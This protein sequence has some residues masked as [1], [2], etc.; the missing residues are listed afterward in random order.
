MTVTSIQVVSVPVADQE[1]AQR[2]YI[3]QLGFETRLDSDAGPDG[4]RWVMLGIPRHPTS[5]TLVT[6]FPDMPAGSLRGLVLGTD[7]IDALHAR[8]RAARVEVSDGIET[9]P[10]GRYFTLYDSEGNGLVIQQAPD[11]AMA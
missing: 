5:I 6:W 4:S 2:F 8:L 3:G 7:D 11:R 9:A 1:R 10:W